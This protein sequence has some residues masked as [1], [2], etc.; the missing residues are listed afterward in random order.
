MDPTPVEWIP[1]LVVLVVALVA[2]AL[3]A[4]RFAGRGRS[5][6]L[7]SEPPVETRDLVAKREALMTQLREIDDTA[8]KDDPA[9][10]ARERY[11]LELAAAQVL[12]EL[13]EQAPV[14]P[15]PAQEEPRP[16]A[17]DSPAL[18][19]F[20]WGTGTMV[21]VGLLLYFVAQQAAPRGE[22]GSVT[23][24]GM[25]SQ[26]ASGS[27]SPEEAR[28]KA[29]LDRN[30]EDLEARLE[31]ARAYLG[32]QDL[33][34]VWNE[35]QF[36]LARDPANPRAT[37]YQALVRLAMGQADM[38]LEMLKKAQAQSP[39]FM[40]GYVH[41]ALVYLR[42]GRPKDAEA[43]IA[44]AVRRF[45]ERKELLRKALD[46]MTAAATALEPVSPGEPDPHAGVGM[47]GET[48]APKPGAATASDRAAP[49]TTGPAV[50][51]T[52]HL[53][54]SVGGAVAQGAVVYVMVRPAGAA[55]GPPLA[56]KRLVASGFPLS[57]EIGSADSM[58]GDEL[59]AEVLVEARLDDD[60]DAAS[61]SPQ[62]PQAR[63]DRVKLGA[64]GVQL[65]LTRGK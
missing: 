8:A 34:G 60:G 57:F 14:A 6:P 23:G 51:G 52:V 3:L 18:K 31:L 49:A 7:S 35:T 58:T 21:L 43:A 10:L 20:L 33:M 39:D 63:Q 38:A 5:V 65:I 12:L 15:A 24:G 11:E 30:P 62:D 40:D 9:H 48:E 25:G 1:S 22:G 42:L 28:A 19:G 64:T 47:P 44:E 54:A 32:R 56:V 59:P 53:D 41:I 26:N 17:G 13:D 27:T 29:T 16:P 4:W 37:S 46:Q 45:P 2:G 50:R 36:I 55:G 61:K